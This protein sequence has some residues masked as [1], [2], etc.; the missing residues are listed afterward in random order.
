ML[1]TKN[2]KSGGGNLRPVIDAGNHKIKINDLTFDQTPYDKDA[3]N[4][5]MHIE[6]E[7]VGGEFQGFLK[8]KTDPNGPRYKGQVGRVRFS[9]YAYRDTV[10]PSG[11][12][13]KR[14]QSVLKA[15]V[16]LA[17]TL[18]VRDELDNIEANT[19]FE[20]MSACRQIFKNSKFFNACIG[21]REWEN[22]DGYVNLDLYLPKISKGKVNI[23]AC[24]VNNSRL[25]EF[26]ATAHIKKLAKKSVSSFEDKDDPFASDDFEL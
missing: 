18:G 7:P 3:Y 1:S 6:T 19:I 13:I 10:L 20:F 9:Q 25:M 16:I 5:T 15:M 26:D 24:D 8:D 2:M 21:G 14:D 12:E 17:E 11:V 4:I 23:E 22:K